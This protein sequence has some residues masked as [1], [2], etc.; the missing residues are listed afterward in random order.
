MVTTQRMSNASLP[1]NS[2]QAGSYTKGQVLTLSCY[3]RGQNVKGY[4][5]R[6][7][8]GGWDNLWYQVDD[9]YFVADVDIN[10]GSDNPV[11]PACGSTPPPLT[12][13]SVDANTWYK[14]TS[15][16]S[17]KVLDVRGG[18]SANGTAVQQY[19]GN[20]TK[21]QMWRFVATDSGFYKIATALNSNEVVDVTGG[22]SANGAKV[23]IWA[24][25]SGANQ[26]W[27]AVDAGSGYVTVRPRHATSQCL[28]VPGGSMTTGLQLQIY[29]CNNTSS[30][31][32][33]LSGLGPI[34]APNDQPGRFQMPFAAG[35]RWQVC[36][37]YNGTISHSGDPAL[38][39][40]TDTSRGT[41]GCYG[42]ASA[43]SGMPIYAPESGTL[44]QVSN[45]FGGT[46]ITFPSGGSMY[47]GHLINRRGNG[48][49]NKGD[50]IGTVAA[51]GQVNN[52]GYSHVH[53]SMR[54]GSGC[55]GSHI[56][57]DNADGARFIGVPNLTNNGTANQWAGTVFQR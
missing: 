51:P 20:N 48:A 57:F 29:A 4:Y 54:S 50:Q 24:D 3:K 53:I 1:P 31:R 37:G 19:L 28:D 16:L 30:Q 39:M 11:T 12:G 8:S 15:Q 21:S 34:S 32:F 38:D 5:S 45:P 9:G 36:Q 18:G 41:S 10:T 14:I 33:A 56:P 44:A 46:C 52:G 26:Q 49:V 42:N 35:Q 43:A 2:A 7:I 40:T 6:Y 22:N 13:I 55:G 27:L 17:N 23:Q 25:G 47:L